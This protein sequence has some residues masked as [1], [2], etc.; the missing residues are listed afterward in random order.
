[1]QRMGQNGHSHQ[2]CRCRQSTI[3]FQIIGVLRPWHVM[4][5]A[6]GL[7]IWRLGRRSFGMWLMWWMGLSSL[8][9]Q[10]MQELKSKKR[11][12]AGF[13]RSKGEV[14]L[15]SWIWGPTNSCLMAPV[16]PHLLVWFVL[17]QDLQWY[18]PLAI[19]LRWGEH[20]L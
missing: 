1:M 5:A 18:S 14:N 15:L 8:Q 9:R 7:S 2:L 6:A 20:P 13:G 11:I 4:V 10:A 16:D 19:P 17:C 3:S 12:F